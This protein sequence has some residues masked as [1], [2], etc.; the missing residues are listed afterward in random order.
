MYGVDPSVLRRQNENASALLALDPR[1]QNDRANP[2]VVTPGSLMAA[3]RPSSSVATTSG[4]V[5]DV[6]AVGA[7][8][9]PIIQVAVVVARLVSSHGDAGRRSPPRVVAFLPPPEP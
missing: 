4:A 3:P 5:H 1:S 9:P 7:E 6:V 8:N 2:V